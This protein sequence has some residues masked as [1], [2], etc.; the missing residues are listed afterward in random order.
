MLISLYLVCRCILFP[1]TKVIVTSNTLTQANEVLLKIQD[2]LM[3]LSPFLRNEIE[4]CNVGQNK[5]E[6]YFKSRS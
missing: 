1:G 4:S 6:I 5:A 2:E 3:P